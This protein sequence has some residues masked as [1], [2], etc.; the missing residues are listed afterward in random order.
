MKYEAL[1]ERAP[2]CGFSQCSSAQYVVLAPQNYSGATV[3]VLP[4]L[5]F[6]LV[7][8]LP[9]ICCTSHWSSIALFCCLV[10]TTSHHYCSSPPGE[11][12]LRPVACSAL[13][14]TTVGLTHRRAIYIQYIQCSVGEYGIALDMLCRIPTA[15]IRWEE[16]WG[17]GSGRRHQGHLVAIWQCGRIAICQCGMDMYNMKVFE[18]LSA[19]LQSQ[20]YL[21]VHHIEKGVKDVT[22]KYYFWR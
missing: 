8:V 11:I 22:V 12:I 18:G 6:S 17:S 20:N 5:V 13:H 21:K 7:C 10:L 16:E 14:H 19:L 1:E 15:V 2:T 4:S 9:L 3:P